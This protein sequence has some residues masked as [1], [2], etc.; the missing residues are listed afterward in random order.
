MSYKDM[1]SLHTI[2]ELRLRMDPDG[3]LADIAE[4]IDEFNDFDSDVLWQ[5]A[6][7][8]SSHEFSKRISYGTPSIRRLNQGVTPSKTTVGQ[9]R[10]PVM[11]TEDWSEIDVKLAGRGGD[12]EGYRY[13]E[14]IGFAESFAQAVPGYFFYG[15]GYQEEILGLANR[16][17][18]L[19]LSNTY[20]GTGTGTL[21]SSIY[22]IDWGRDVFGIYPTGS[23]AGLDFADKGIETKESSTTLMEVYRSRWQWDFGLV[24]RDD[25][26][27]ARIANVDVSDPSAASPDAI[28]N[29]M[30]YALNKFPHGT[31]GSGVVAY[32]NSDTMT[33]LDILVKDKTNMDYGWSDKFGRPV[34]AFRDSIPFRQVDQI[35]SSEAQVS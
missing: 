25:R 19:S 30:I 31:R 18:A 11:M 26:K 4:V 6:N 23:N 1:T 16:M 15:T 5:E 29:V 22:I 17:N 13:Q 32:C 2:G 21:L 12:P 28:D 3:M 10:E 20:N 33:I 34:R 24:V 14:D 8:K 7:D 27:I 9:D 35:L